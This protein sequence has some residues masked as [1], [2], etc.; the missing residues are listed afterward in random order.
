MAFFQRLVGLALLLT[1]SV[2]T[3]APPLL[4]LPIECPR[5]ADCPIQNYVDHDDG[6]LGRDYACGTLTY[7]GHTG[8]DF[9]VADLP[10]MY[11]GVKVLAAA[12]GTVVAVRDGEPDVSVRQRGRSALA[13]RDAG[14]S[15][16]IA[17]GDGWESQY[18]HLR[19]GSVAVRAGQS[20]A[21]GTRLGEVG[22]SGNTE[23]PHVDF[24]LRHQGKIVDPFAPDSP[25][26][27]CGS[28][29]ATLWDPS[30]AER[31]NY[32]ASGLLSAGFAAEPAQRERAEA[33]DYAGVELTPASAA[34]VFWV[35]LFGVQKGD[36]VQMQLSRPDGQ[37]L[38][39]SRTIAE[40]NKAVWFALVGK[41][42]TAAWPVGDYRGR[43]TLLRG[44]IVVF[45][46][47]RTIFVR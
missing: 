44:E 40:G 7:D 34:M 42:R 24:T 33:G 25:P 5:G 23:F 43:V 3:A 11:A 27:A 9:R 6:P 37:V 20:V 10:A 31:L 46:A 26:Q 32:R 2:A 14:N 15:V 21:A 47:T 18:S 38:A 22:L 4:G 17:H 19:R 1:I 35:S 36:R 8:T 12:A 45:D 30:V 16:R 29:G 41:R 28:G 13:G 39:D